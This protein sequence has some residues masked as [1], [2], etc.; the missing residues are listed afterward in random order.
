MQTL[1]LAVGQRLAWPRRRGGRRRAGR[2]ARPRARPRP[3]SNRLI[4][5]RSASSASNRSSWVCS[6][7]ALRATRRVEARRARRGGRRRPSARSSA[8]SAARA[9]RR[10]RTGAASGTAPP[11][12]WIWRCRFVRHL[13]ERRRRAGRCRPRRAPSSAPRAGRRRAAR[14]SAAAIRTGVT[15]CRVTSQAMAPSRTTSASRRRATSALRDQVRGSSSSWSQREE[16]V[17]LVGADRRGRRPASPTTRPAPSA[18]TSRGH[19]AVGPLLGRP[20]SSTRV[21]QRPAGR[22]VGVDAAASSRPERR[23]RVVDV[24]TPAAARPRGCRS[25]RRRG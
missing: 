17:Q 15:T 1:R 5:S 10:R 11:A 2:S 9:T 20:A 8:V 22:A 21:A 25:R 14:R 12:G 6:S 3:A 4:S 23:P 18:P 19:R 24:L 13:V 16:V 7:S